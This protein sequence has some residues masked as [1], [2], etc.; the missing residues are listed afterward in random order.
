MVKYAETLH[1]VYEYQIGA[2]AP[3]K[4]IIQ[5]TIDTR[6]TGSTSNILEVA[7]GA[8]VMFLETIRE[9]FLRGI[10]SDVYR[11]HEVLE[12]LTPSESGYID[13]EVHE[14]EGTGSSHSGGNPKGS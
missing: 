4:V 3:Q 8:S 10:H 9:K 12:G 14:R 11:Y 2:R 7:E 6:I 5:C 1:F 13:V